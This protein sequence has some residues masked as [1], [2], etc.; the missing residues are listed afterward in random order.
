MRAGLES[1]LQ[2][3]RASGNRPT[4]CLSLPGGA[5]GPASSRLSGGQMAASDQDVLLRLSLWLADVAAET[6]VA[7]TAPAAAVARSAG[8]ADEPP[9]VESAS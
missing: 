3:R 4:P 8:R 5:A 1:R 9:V 2:M 6:T 7:A